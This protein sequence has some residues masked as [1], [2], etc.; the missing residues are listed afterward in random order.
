M[1]IDTRPARSSRVLVLALLCLLTAT[2]AGAQDAPDV[3]SADL[4]DQGQ[5]RDIWLRINARDWADLQNH[6]MD[7]TYYPADFEW[8]GMVVHNVGIRSRGRASRSATKP[9]LSVDFNRYVSGQTFLGLKS[10]VLDNQWQDPSMMHERLSML[11]FQ[12]LGI[13]APRETYARLYVGPDREFL[14]VYG[15]V[16]SI[17]KTFLMRTLQENDGHLYEYTNVEPYHFEDSDQDLRW[18]A[19]RFEPKTHENE[20]SWSLYS[21]IKNLV[22]TV[23][24][25]DERR[26]QEDLPEYL[27]LRQVAAFLAIQNVLS[28]KDGLVGVFGMANFY[29]YRFQAKRMFQFIPWDQ[30]LAFDDLGLGPT[31]RL[32]TNILATRIWTT[33]SLREYYLSAMSQ[34]ERV[35]DEAVE[36][37]TPEGVRTCTWLEREIDVAYAQIREAVYRDPAKPYAIDTFEESVEFLRTFA[38]QRSTVLGTFMEQLGPSSRR[39]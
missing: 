19:N 9:G 36:C 13:A 18:F 15:V 38:R 35:L 26:M 24:M 37:Q 23:N 5:M 32:D 28:Q 16:E 6:F 14:G 20:S 27:D 4:F 31:D 1:T 11:V 17:D 21:P 10:L 22:Q 25:Q 30:D 12:R 39:P 29:L 2:R 7:S 34:T 3:T 8:N 33:P